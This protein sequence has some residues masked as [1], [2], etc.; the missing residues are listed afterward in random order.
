MNEFWREA[1]KDLLF[2]V[3]GAGV[4]FIPAAIASRRER[5]ENRKQ[6]DYIFRR[7]RNAAVTSSLLGGLS[8]L[9]N[10]VI[11]LIIYDGTIAQNEY[12]KYLRV[13]SEFID[14]LNANA[15]EAQL[16]LAEPARDQISELQEVIN[17]V[18]IDAFGLYPGADNMQIINEKI[19]T[20][21]DALKAQVFV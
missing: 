18:H 1:L 7:D 9:Q 10:R 15:G 19:N 21:I 3:V 16:F 17:A 13:Y 14:I 20:T 2:I 5:E 8:L 12:E 4:G 11:Y 6:G